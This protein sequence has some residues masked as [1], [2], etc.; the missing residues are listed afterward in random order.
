MFQRLLAGRTRDIEDIKAILLKNP[1]YDRR[2]ISQWLKEFDKSLTETF[3]AVFKK[4]V[5][6]TKGD[7]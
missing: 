5:K 6:E 7:Y 1:D 2:Y 4:V 3:S